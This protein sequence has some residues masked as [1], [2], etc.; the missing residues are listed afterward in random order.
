MARSSA[1]FY[2]WLIRVTNLIRAQQDPE[3]GEPFELFVRELGEVLS[4]DTLSKFDATSA[5]FH[6]YAGPGFEKLGEELKRIYAENVE[7][8]TAESQIL[9]VWVYAH[10]ETIVLG[11]LDKETRFSTIPCMR[12]AG[13]QSVCAIP[14]SDPHRRLGSLVIASVRRDAYSPEDVRFATL[15]ANQIALA[16]DDAINFREAQRAR[17]RLALLLDLTN[18]VVSKLDLRDVLREIC[19]NIR[20]VMECDAVGITLPGPENRKLYIYAL[21]FPEGPSVIEEGRELPPG[22]KAL[23]ERVSQSGEAMILSG[24]E[25]EPEPLWEPAAIRSA[26]HVPLKGT[27]GSRRRARDGE[28]ERGR[29]CE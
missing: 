15:A 5:T 8:N 22:V 13:L 28:P 3:D 23:V 14:L 27:G 12:E 16:M 10:Q 29:V 18:R 11:S 21:A 17:D 26:A 20:R 7:R 2:E 9:A 1:E 25:F 24:E 4:F 19:A 6:W